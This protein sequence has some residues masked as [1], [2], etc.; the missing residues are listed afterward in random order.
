MKRDGRGD[1]GMVRGVGY[2]VII[3]RRDGFECCVC[4]VCRKC[5]CASGGWPGLHLFIDQKF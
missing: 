3:R 1:C 5:A 4:G 2:Y